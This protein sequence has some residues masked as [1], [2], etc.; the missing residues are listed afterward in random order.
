MRNKERLNEFYAVLSEVHK[1][2]FPDWRFGQLIQNFLG[3]YVH[4]Y[5]SDIFYLE[6]D[7]MIQ[8]IYIYA[9]EES[10]WFRGWEVEN[11]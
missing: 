5:K 7:R 3:W 10:P 11:D 6:E 1:R 9:N 8:R 4:K 2:S